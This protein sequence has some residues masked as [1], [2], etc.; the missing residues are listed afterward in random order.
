MI[1]VEIVNTCQSYNK[2]AVFM[3]SFLLVSSMAAFVIALYINK[4]IGDGK[5]EIIIA[6]IIIVWC[7]F[8]I[9]DT[10]SHPYTIYEA[11][12]DET[13]SYLELANEYDDIK[14]YEDVWI[15]KK[16]EVSK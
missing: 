6:G 3:Y 14:Q 11:R 7:I 9:I 4:S 8:T 16:Y 5:T 2:F 15:L 10:I 12:I 13:V 1:G